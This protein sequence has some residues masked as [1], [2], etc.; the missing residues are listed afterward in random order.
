MIIGVP[1]EIKDNEYRVSVTPGGVHQLVEEGHQ[2][3]IERGAGEGS[4][5]TDR[6]YMEAG[7]EIVADA[8]D[9]WHRAEMVM[10]VKEPLPQEYGYL[11]EGLILYTYLH[12]AADEEL[13][14]QLVARKFTGIAYETVE[15]P[16]G[17][18]PLHTPM[19]EVA[20]TMSVQI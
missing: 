8:A 18:L 19:S 17:T 1:K 20:G 13:T 11:R 9:V 14:R 15:L 5:F 7:A 3:L 12:L 6:E 16:D 2:V 10:K 4:G